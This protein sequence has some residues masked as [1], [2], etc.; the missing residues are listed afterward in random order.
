MVTGLILTSNG[1]ISIGRNKKRTIKSMVYKHI[2]NQL[3]P[4]EESYLQG[5]L[6]YIN[7][8]EPSFIQSLKKKY[9]AEIILKLMNKGAH[10][11]KKAH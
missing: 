5:Y 11:S 9:T 10:I 1:R 3:E 7:S 2:N 6:S 8:V 4:N